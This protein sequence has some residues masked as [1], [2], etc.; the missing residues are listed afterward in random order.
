MT[1]R[2]PVK[3]FYS[4][5]R[6]LFLREVQVR[7]GAK[8]LGYFWA[9]AEPMVV[10]VVFV[11]IKQ[12]IHPRSFPGISYPVFLA[13]GM[14]AYFMFRNIVK[15]TLDAF[16]ANKGLFVYKQVK[17]FD[18]FVARFV[19]EVALTY[20]IA[21]IF[22]FIGWYIGYDVVPSSILGVVVGY[23]WIAVFGFSIG[24]FSAVLGYFFDN[25]KKIIHML[26]TPLFFLSGLFYTLDALPALARE[27]L[28][29]NPVIHFIELIHAS[30]FDSLSANYVDFRYMTF[31]TLIPLFLGLWF[32]M[33]TERKIIMS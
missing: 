18:A 7:F 33:K 30:Y 21:V 13:S 16:D 5:V 4:V 22:L 14:I 3:I 15:R 24:V 9:I 27:F 25:F 20:L 10:I 6:A 12:L 28:L 31:W 23:L 11:A 26:F 17:P 29:Y 2:N 8:K 19:L 32:Y 1:K